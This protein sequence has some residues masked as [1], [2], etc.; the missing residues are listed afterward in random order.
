MS[1]ISI[2]SR[3]IRLQH[4]GRSC[5]SYSRD[6]PGFVEAI[7][8]RVGGHLEFP[9]RHR[10]APQCMP[11]HALDRARP[12]AAWFHCGNGQL[13]LVRYVV[14]TCLY[15]AR[16]QQYSP[17]VSH[18]LNPASISDSLFPYS[19]SPTFD[20][21]GHGVFEGL[22]RRRPDRLRQ[23]GGLVHVTQFS[24][25]PCRPFGLGHCCA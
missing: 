20:E 4:F 15:V 23:T 5:A 16:H 1:K 25:D 6:A 2:A 8:F 11:S 24:S 22:Q 14:R 12:T 9:G 7:A 13:L 19:S 21:F 17:C 18:A 3:R 10:L